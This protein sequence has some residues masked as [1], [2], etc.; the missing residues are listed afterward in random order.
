VKAS[1]TVA[2]GTGAYKHIKGSG[3]VSCTTTDNGKTFHCIV[4][5]TATL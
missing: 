5:G 4:K 3:T 1:V 2:S